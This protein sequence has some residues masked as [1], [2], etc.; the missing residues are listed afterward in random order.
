MEGQVRLI[1]QQ[2]SRLD[3]IN[4]PV[5]CEDVS[6]KVALF[7]HFLR[8]RRDLIRKA[9]MELADNASVFLNQDLLMDAIRRL[10]QEENHGHEADNRQSFHKYGLSAHFFTSL[11]FLYVI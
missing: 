10:R 4:D 11:F 5:P 8:N 9:L 6:P 7:G 3:A 1:V 2:S